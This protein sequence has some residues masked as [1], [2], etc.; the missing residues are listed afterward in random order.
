MVAIVIEH[1]QLVGKLGNLQNTF[2]DHSVIK[3]SNEIMAQK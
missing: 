1:S 2:C 3:S